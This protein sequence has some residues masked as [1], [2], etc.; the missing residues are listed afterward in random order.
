MKKAKILLAALAVVTVVGGSLAFKAKT[1]FGGK[2]YYTTNVAGGIATAT[3]SD[4]KT[5]AATTE[6]FHEYYTT[7]FSSTVSTEP[8]YITTTAL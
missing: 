1:A 6:A 2:M 8:T 3:L 7:I 4:A 5:V